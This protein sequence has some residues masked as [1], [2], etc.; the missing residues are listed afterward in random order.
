MYIKTFVAALTFAIVGCF[1]PSEA[2]QPEEIG[3]AGETAVIQSCPHEFRATPCEDAND[4][5]INQC[6]RSTCEN[7]LCQ[8]KPYPY[9]QL[10]ID[11]AD[12]STFYVGTCSAC[13]CRP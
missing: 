5:F 7:G 13:Y 10:C 11:S 2:E 9:G 12:G 6:T 4:C 1:V 8:H 3:E